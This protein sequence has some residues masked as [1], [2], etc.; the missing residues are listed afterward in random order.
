MQ[1]D[2]QSQASGQSSMQADKRLDYAAHSLQNI[3]QAL[4]PPE[5]L[6]TCKLAQRAYK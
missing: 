4:S 5:V 3:G 2:R 6:D 1:R